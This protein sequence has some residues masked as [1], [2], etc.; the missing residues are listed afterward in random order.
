MRGLILALGTLLSGCAHAQQLPPPAQ[1]VTITLPAA[2]WNVV[3]QG[4]G[5]LPLKTAMPVLQ[6]I[7]QQAAPQVAPKSV[8]PK[9]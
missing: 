2:D 6:N 7:Q 9:K 8:E 4:L 1:V 3:L 5:E